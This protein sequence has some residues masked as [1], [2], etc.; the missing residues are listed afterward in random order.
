MQLV[1]FNGAITLNMLLEVTILTAV[2]VTTVL[3]W[4]YI[5][6]KQEKRLL[7]AIEAEHRFQHKNQA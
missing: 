6:T 1:G 7:D 3:V 4:A 2:I 5:D